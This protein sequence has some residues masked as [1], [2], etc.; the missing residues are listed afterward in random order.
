[1]FE[2]LGLGIDSAFASTLKSRDVK[3]NKKRTRQKNVNGKLK[4]KD[5]EFTKYAKGHKEQMDAL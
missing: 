3:K 2:E 1:M 4:R 5:G